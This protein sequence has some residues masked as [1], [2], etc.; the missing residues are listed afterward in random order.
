[1]EL[2]EGRTLKQCLLG[3]RL[4]VDE[5]L[6][7]AF[8]VADALEAA[9]ARGIIHRDIKPANIFLTQHGQ[10]KL[11]DFGLAKLAPEG[12]AAAEAP[13]ALP[14]AQPVPEQL[15]GPGTAV[16]TVSYMSPEQALGKELDAG[17]DLF[18]LGVVLYEMTTG[19]LPFRG[20]TSV[21]VFDSIL[22]ETP[23]APV[24][25]NPDV[26]GELERIINKALE[27]DREIRYQSARDLLVDLTRL[28][29]ERETGRMA[30]PGVAAAPRIRSLAVLPFTNM[31]ADRE[32]EYFCDGLSEEIISA[33]SH[34]RELRVVART[35]AFA[36][37]GREI[38]IREVGK[39][40]NVGAVL[41]GSVRKSG[42]RLRITAQLINVED[43]Y[44]PG[45]GEKGP[46]DRPRGGR[47]PR[48]SGLDRHVVRLGLA[49]G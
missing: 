34:I 6:T 15:T 48:L 28:R 45:R 19:S 4:G 35:S 38:D 42:Q 32:N 31:S 11:L 29:R 25:L 13:T 22:H 10:T 36:F 2:L 41:E 44:H 47:G 49:G 17:T 20:D 39:R 5:I 7:V 21:A 26:P 27:K 40:L 14:T 12:R 9:H 16:G 37:K 23:T 46:G 43:G 30:V 3:E 1:M 18:S 33:L 8:E 24:R